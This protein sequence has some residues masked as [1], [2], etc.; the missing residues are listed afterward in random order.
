MP[1]PTGPL[2]IVQLTAENVKRLRAVDIS[3]DGTAAVVEITGRNAQGKTSLLDAIWLA[4]GGPAAQ[5]AIG[6]PVRDGETTASV[7]LDLGD[8]VVTR[9]WNTELKSPTSLRVENREGARYPSPQAVL[10]EL[11]GRLS[12][13][14][15]AFVGLPAKEQVAT[16]L[17]LVDLPFAPEELA[18][19]REMAFNRRTEINRD[20][21]RAAA[22]L[23][24]APQP[25]VGTPSEPVRIA[26]LV[27]A[28]DAADH[29]LGQRV[30]AEATVGQRLT[31]A[32][33][34]DNAAD[35]AHREYLAAGVRLA[36][37]QAAQRDA[38]GA[39]EAARDAVVD[40]P[41][42]E[43]LLGELD[44]ANAA[45]D[46]VEARNEAVRAQAARQALAD[47]VDALTAQ[48][49]EWTDRIRALDDRKRDGLAA[50]AMPIDGLAF[51]EAGLTYQ[52]VP[53]AQCSSAERI[54]VSLAMAM[55]LNPT[56]RVIRVFDGSLLDSVNRAA[57]EAMCVERGYQVWIETV[58]SGSTVAVVIEDGSVVGA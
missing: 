46:E 40:L 37:A 26:D 14:P 31:D 30:Q 49:A 47:E 22:A 15:L 24:K 9:T 6:N 11:V 33:A 1:R 32:D 17:Q 53:F 51:D 8:L 4:L 5:R 45:I 18:Y 52:G 13:D 23:Q 21:A 28:R 16:L 42:R 39:V 38:L 54:R 50:A 57:V 56:L 25:P 35:A 48:V 29:A 2:R 44:G 36:A 19:D 10:D 58:D 20:L 34:A 41:S 3:P 7:R 27:A 55:A 12:F 43:Y